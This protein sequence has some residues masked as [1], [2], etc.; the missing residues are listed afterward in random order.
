MLHTTNKKKLYKVPVLYIFENRGKTVVSQMI[1]FF[2]LV[3]VVVL[4]PYCSEVIRFGT[5]AFFLGH[6]K[7]TV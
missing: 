4:H 1:F 6:F 5:R 2:F 3:V 7:S